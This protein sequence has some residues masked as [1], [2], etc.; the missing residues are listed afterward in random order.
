MHVH[1]FSA[2]VL[3]MNNNPI[4]ATNF[5]HIINTL[6]SQYWVPLHIHYAYR[7]Y[8]ILLYRNNNV[9][10]LQYIMRYI[11]RA[12][13]FVFAC[14]HIPLLANLT[15]FAC[16]FRSSFSWRPYACGV[17]DRLTAAYSRR[18]LRYCNSYKLYPPSYWQRINN[19][20]R[21]IQLPWQYGHITMPAVVVTNSIQCVQLLPRT[22][23]WRYVTSL[24]S[25][26]KLAT[27]L[28]LHQRFSLRA[29]VS[30]LF[31]DY[32]H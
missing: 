22:P 26:D 3:H 32:L 24:C 21:S 31:C 4:T 20:H 29:D 11:I 25:I 1:L 19:T 16:S 8:T 13:A 23:A 18:V 17:L 27:I 10:E 6:P 12:Y 15:V 9:W 7:H 5:T 28:L 14:S 30:S 2:I